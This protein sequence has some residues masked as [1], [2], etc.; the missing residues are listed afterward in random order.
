MFLLLNYWPYFPNGE[1]KEKGREE[2]KVEFETDQED[3]KDIRK[4]SRQLSDFKFQTIISIK[5]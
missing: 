2:M 5:Y 1:E 3:N 4:M